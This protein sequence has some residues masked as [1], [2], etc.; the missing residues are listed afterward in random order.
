M[1]ETRGRRPGS[2]DKPHI[3]RGFVLRYRNGGWQVNHGRN[4][5]RATEVSVQTM[6]ITAPNG[7]LHGAGVVTRR[8][9]ALIITA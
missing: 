3:P 5:V 8:G 9:S 7:E 1:T 4:W 6:V 2:H